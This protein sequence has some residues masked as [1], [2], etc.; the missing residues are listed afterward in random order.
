MP[1]DKVV[2]VTGAARGI[3]KG[4]ASVVAT[5][6]ASIALVDIEQS[7]LDETA[8]ELAA[9]NPVSQFLEFEADISDEASVDQCFCAIVQRFEHNDG[10]VNNAAI[11]ADRGNLLDNDPKNAAVNVA[12]AIAC[13]NAFVNHARNRGT[14]GNIASAGGI[15]SHVLMGPLQL[16]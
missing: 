2:V 16:D 9:I 5:K 11:V 14:G 15:E 10:L 8:D 1:T 7:A 3:G 6:G 12:G 13:S 4:I